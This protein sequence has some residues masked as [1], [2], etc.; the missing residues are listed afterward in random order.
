MINLNK[1][2]NDVL[3]DIVSINIPISTKI[4]PKI[5]IDEGRYDRVGACYKYKFPERYEIHLSQ[6]VLQATEYE[7]KNIIAHEML[8]T[9]YLCMPH[10]GAWKVY[11][12]KMNKHLGYN[13]QVE[14]SWAEILDI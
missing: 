14:Y 8:H 13:I 10:D 11:Q 12:R 9:C 1:L 5:Y 3:N 7:I 4:I 6:D 2:F